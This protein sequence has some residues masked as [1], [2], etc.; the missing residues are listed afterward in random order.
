M[1]PLSEIVNGFKPLDVFAKNLHCRC[2]LVLATSM[3]FELI[4]TEWEFVILTGENQASKMSI[5]LS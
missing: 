3:H 5:T 2:L 4:L 1:E